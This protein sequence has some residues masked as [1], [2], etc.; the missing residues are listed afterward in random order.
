MSKLVEKVGDPGLKVFLSPRH[1]G[2]FQITPKVGDE[3]CTTDVPV[4]LY[5]KVKF[6]FFLVHQM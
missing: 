5:L 3:C 6:V 1:S 2:N 4:I